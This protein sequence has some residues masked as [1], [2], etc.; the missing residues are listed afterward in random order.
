MEKVGINLYQI[1]PSKCRKDKR[2]KGQIK[3]FKDYG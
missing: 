2:F 3:E 1:K